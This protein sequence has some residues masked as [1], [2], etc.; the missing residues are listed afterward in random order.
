MEVNMS[1]RNI[2]LVMLVSI[3]AIFG[4]LVVYDVK[5]NHRLEKIFGKET[6]ENWQ[7]KDNWNSKQPKIQEPPKKEQEKQEKTKPQVTVSNYNDA[8]KKSSELG[9][10]IV[11]I[12]R[13]EWCHWCKK[14]Q[15]ETLL[16]SKVKSMMTN[17][18]FLEVDVDADTVTAKKFGVFGLPSYVITNS[19]GDKLKSG[20]G[21][22]NGDL[23]SEWLNEPT[24]F[25]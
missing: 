16:D 12:F 1:Q 9:I 3:I 2:M 19:K 17:Y 18:V 6:K 20:S 21:Y 4:A 11:I 23:F 14:L 5:I 22:K 25:K 15:K 7:W 24:M 10:P 13:A 8:V